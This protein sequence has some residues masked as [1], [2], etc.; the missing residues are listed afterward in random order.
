M[1]NVNLYIWSEN[2]LKWQISCQFLQ[3]N[4]KSDSRQL[5]KS[6]TDL[7]KCHKT[8]RMGDAE[9]EVNFLCVKVKCLP[10]G[11]PQ[12]TAAAF[13]YQIC[14]FLSIISPA[15]RLPPCPSLVIIIKSGGGASLIRLISL[16]SAAGCCGWCAKH[17]TCSTL[18]QPPPSSG[19]WSWTECFASNS[20]RLLN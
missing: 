20:A 2:K 4:F 10:S 7:S 3:I 9:M 11:S 15:R 17:S 13:N 8:L 5:V 6:N 19:M 16:S 14:H 18:A 12:L 1:Y